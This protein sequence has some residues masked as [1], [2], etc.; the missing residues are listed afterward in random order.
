MRGKYHAYPFGDFWEHVDYPGA[1][2]ERRKR[3]GPT[4]WECRVANEKARA[5]HVAELEARIEELE[6]ELADAKA[7]VYNITPQRT[8]DD[9]FETL[10]EQIDFLYQ[11]I[12]PDGPRKE[13]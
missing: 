2:E 10:D 12:R 11:Q 5:Q 4:A 7:F 3:R 1:E 8:E 13:E 6:A 9:L